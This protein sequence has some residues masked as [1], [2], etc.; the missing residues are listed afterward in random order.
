MLIGAFCGGVLLCGLGAG[1]AFIEFTEL[2][3]GG[4]QYLG[5]T[6][7]RTEDFDVEFEPGEEK[8]DVIGLYHWVEEGLTV[9]QKIPE[10]TV[11]LRVTYNAA[12]IEPH[13]RL[14]EDNDIVLYYHMEDEDDIALVM[15][16]K[17][18]ILQNLK[19]GSIV[20]LD[21]IGIEEINVLVNPANVEDVRVQY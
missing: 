10:N 14:D 19:A 5:K 16:A 18:V 7:M 4:T 1:I 17:D 11:R 3:Y 12:R 15:E 13:A 2:H 9:D 20:S 8:T 6:Q 21:T